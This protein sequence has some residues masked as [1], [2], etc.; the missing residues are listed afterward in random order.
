MGAMLTFL[1]IRALDPY[2]LS[3][4][5]QEALIADQERDV[6]SLI[7]PEIQSGLKESGIDLEEVAR[8]VRKEALTSD[9]T[10]R[11]PRKVSDP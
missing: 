4:Q 11:Q 9:K 1:A 8:Q 3:T 5:E 6:T 2:V 10:D 7:D